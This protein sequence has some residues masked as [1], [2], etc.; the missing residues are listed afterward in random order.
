M[1]SQTTDDYGSQPR[2][3]E[4]VMFE[5]EVLCELIRLHLQVLKRMPLVQLLL[6]SGL[7]LLV[8]RPLDSPVVLFGWAVLTVAAE[9]LR[10]VYA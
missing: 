4:Q 3:T 1:T 9:C 8:Y 6:V 5:R 7:A 2:Q 10:A